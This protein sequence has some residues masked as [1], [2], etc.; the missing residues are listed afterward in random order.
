MKKLPL[1]IHPEKIDFRK[2]FNYVNLL[3]KFQISSYIGTGIQQ[4]IFTEISP[5]F[6]LIIDEGSSIPVL[7]FDS[8]STGK[9]KRVDGITI[10]NGILGLS[11]TRDGFIVGVNALIN[12]NAITY[13]Y[14]CLGE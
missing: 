3:P 8:F 9:S 13:K 6:V 12:T 4:N 1:D 11:S 10:T 7:W 2:L 5:K 14:L